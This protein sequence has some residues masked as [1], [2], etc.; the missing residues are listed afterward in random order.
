MSEAGGPLSRRMTPMDRREFLKGGAAT[1]G[2]LLLSACGGRML[3]GLRE[4]AE[5]AAPDP[6]T[7]ELADLALAAA[8]EAG[9][10]YADI[11]IADYRRQLVATREERVETVRDSEDRGFTYRVGAKLDM[12]MDPSESGQ[13]AADVLAY[14]EE[15]ESK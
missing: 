15:K 6:R 11:R 3:G 8:R 2:L 5:P 1:G 14:E 12:R 10:S 7:R 9:A 13:T 4:R